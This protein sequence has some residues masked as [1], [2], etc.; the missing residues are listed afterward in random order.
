VEWNHSAAAGHRRLANVASPPNAARR[1]SFFLSFD[2]SQGDGVESSM[3][4]IFFLGAAILA[5]SLLGPYAP[6]PDLIGGIALAAVINWHFPLV[7]VVQKPKS[8]DDG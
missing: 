6:T 5:V 4:W 2:S 3:K 1:G 8:R 7:R